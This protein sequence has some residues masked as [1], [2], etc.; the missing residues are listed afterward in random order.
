LIKTL[1]GEH[2]SRL[3]KKSQRF[4]EKADGREFFGLLWVH[5]EEWTSA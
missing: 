5:G 4:G 3:L 1:D 2:E